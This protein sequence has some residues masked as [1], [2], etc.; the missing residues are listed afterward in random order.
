M[1][2]SARGHRTEP[3]RDGCCR[4]NNAKPTLP[5]PGPAV[6]RWAGRPWQRWARLP[7]LS[8]PP[9]LTVPLCVQAQTTPA[10]AS[11][12]EEQQ[13]FLRLTG[14]R[15]AAGQPPDERGVAQARRTLRLWVG[16]V[17]GVHPPGRR[18]RPGAAFATAPGLF[19][20]LV[21]M[22]S[23]PLAFSFRETQAPPTTGKA[24]CRR[25]SWPRSGRHHRIQ[26]LR[27]RSGRR[28][29]PCRTCRARWGNPCRGAARRLW[30]C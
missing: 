9:S 6:P 26:C 10:S 5:R 25:T 4:S 24:R 20:T 18:Q 22:F 16:P 15:S 1:P 17:P 19:T 14:A 3:P 21:V 13:T 29:H 27:R 11:C 2:I 30:P 12:Q 7:G 28:F 23:V 8:L